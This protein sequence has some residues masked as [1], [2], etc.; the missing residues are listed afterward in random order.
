M[1]ALDNIWDDLKFKGSLM[2]IIPG[3]VD[4]IRSAM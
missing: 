3:D 2:E 4:M 1:L